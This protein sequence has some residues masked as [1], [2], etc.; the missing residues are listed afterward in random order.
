MNWQ[1]DKSKLLPYVLIGIGVLTLLAA[2][3]LPLTQDL[4]FG[5]VTGGVLIFFQNNWG[6]IL[7]GIIIPLIV[8]LI[9]RD[10]KAKNQSS[11]SLARALLPFFVI[12]VVAWLIYSAGSAV[13]G[14]LTQ[15]RM[16]SPTVTSQNDKKLVENAAYKYDNNPRVYIYKNG[17]L[18]VVANEGAFFSH[19]GCPHLGQITRCAP[20]YTMPEWVTQN[21]ISSEWIR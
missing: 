18:Y 16:T 2:I 5:L 12:G 20:V 9:S 1:N 7:I 21:M 3:I 4:S 14:G 13:W 11:G 6:K 10:L 8:F 17:L 15:P 19:Y